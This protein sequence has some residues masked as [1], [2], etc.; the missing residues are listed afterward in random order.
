[1][2]SNSKKKLRAKAVQLS[3]SNYCRHWDPSDTGY[4]YAQLTL[5]QWRGKIETAEISRNN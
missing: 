2:R 3:V 4:K 1:M 5:D